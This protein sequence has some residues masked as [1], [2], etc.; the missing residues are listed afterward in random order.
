[1]F[2]RWIEDGLLEVLEEK[3]VGCIPFSPLAQG[4]LT[5]RYLNG[6]PEGSRMAGESIFLKKDHLDPE[7][8]VKVKA[9]NQHAEQR[10]Q[11]LAQ[12]AL[13]WILSRKQITSVL[14]GASSVAQLEA[15]A[16]TV[17]TLDFT[18]D[19]LAYIENILV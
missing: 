14:I 7:T 11:T 13:A 1:M 10:G 2:D 15:N 9:L 8:M 17:I 19:E 4:L 3:G 18:R 12:M 6:I 5:D 16:A